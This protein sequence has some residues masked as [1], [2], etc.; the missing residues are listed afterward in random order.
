MTMWNYLHDDLVRRIVELAPAAALP[1]LILVE[2]R[3]RD[4]CSERLSKMAE[5]RQ[6]PF[7][8]RITTSQVLGLEAEDISRCVNLGLLDLKDKDVEVFA[9]ACAIG[10]LDKVTKLDLGDNQFGDVGVSALADAMSKGALASVA[11]LNL[12]SNNIGDAGMDIFAKACASGVL[13]KC[14]AGDIHLS[15]NP[16][17]SAPVD[18]V[19]RARKG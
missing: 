1:T 16:G 11:R 12:S 8:S 5:L 18:A 19:M 7:R 2:L 9:S 14:T 15:G 4:Q 6:P 10:G 3:C 13:S 17:N